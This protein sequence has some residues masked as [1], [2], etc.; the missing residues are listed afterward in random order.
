MLRYRIGMGGHSPG[1]VR[2]AFLSAVEAYTD[3]NGIGPEPMVE[4]E[5]NYEPHLMPISKVCGLVWNCTDC[6]PR[7]VWDDLVDQDITPGRSTYAAAARAMLSQ[8]KA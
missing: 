2:N 7:G 3:W 5:V 4:V 6:L 8:L 1:H